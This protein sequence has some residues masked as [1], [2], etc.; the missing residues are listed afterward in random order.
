MSLS[1]NQRTCTGRL[2]EY[3]AIIGAPKK[4]EVSEEYSLGEETPILHEYF[5]PEVLDR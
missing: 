4:L 5:V 1:A 3:F 2:H